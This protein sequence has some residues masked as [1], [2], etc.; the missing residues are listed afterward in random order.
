MTL[1]EYKSSIGK[2]DKKKIPVNHFPGTASTTDKLLVR[3]KPC[4]VPQQTRLVPGPNEPYYSANPGLNSG[5]AKLPPPLLPSS[6][7]KPTKCEKIKIDKLLR[8][9]KAK[10][11]GLGDRD[12]NFLLEVLREQKGDVDRIARWL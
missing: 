12:R 5:G 9:E 2:S 7:L 3:P 8:L 10:Q 11:L 4:P 6:I 1:C